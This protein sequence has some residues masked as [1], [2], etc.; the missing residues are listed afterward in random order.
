MEEKDNYIQISGTVKALLFQNEENGYTVIKL[1]TTDGEDITVVGCLPYASPGERL[2]V[3]GE[4]TKHSVHGEQFKADWAERTMPSGA[5][6]IY[7]YLASRALRGIGPA[8]ATIIVSEFG[9]NTLS[10]IENEPERLAQIR[11]IGRKKAFE[12]SDA[13]KKQV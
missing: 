9:A 5:E 13:F 3:T 6:A 11:G 1:E 10:V 12:I 4:Y 7:E 2:T 8:T